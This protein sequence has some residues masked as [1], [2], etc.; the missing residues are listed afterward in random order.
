M[1]EDHH[2]KIM[3][4]KESFGIRFKKFLK[5][6]TWEDYA[7]IAIILLAVIFYGVHTA[8]YKTVPS[9]VFG[10]DVY[11]DRGFVKNIAE[12]NAIWSDAFYLNEIQYYGYIAPAFEA[13]VVKIFNI[14]VDTVFLYSGLIFLIISL[15]CWY[16]LG[17]GFFGDKKLALITAIS[18]LVFNQY[19]LKFAYVAGG[20]FVPLFLYYWIKYEKNNKIIDGVLTG[21]M[22]GLTCLIYGGYLIPLSAIFFG[23]MIISFFK[24]VF[25]DMKFK[26]VGKNLGNQGKIILRYIKKYYI[27]T[28]AFALLMAT[29]FVPL[30][31]KYQ[32]KIVNGVPYWGDISPS[33]LNFGWFIGLIRSM[34]FNYSNVLLFIVSVMC[35]LGIV[36]LLLS[37]SSLQ[38]KIILYSVLIDLV[39]VIHHWITVPL[40]KTYFWPS[41]MLIMPFFL[42]L[43]FVVGIKFVIG[44]I[45]KDEKNN[46][47]QWILYAAIAL[48]LIVSTT[49]FISMKNSQWELYGTQS[50]PYVDQLYALAGHIDN[51][52]QNN[53]VILSNDETGFMLAVLSGRK[54]M[55][56]RRTHA[57]YYV[58]IDKRIADASVAM[59]GR[60]INLTK[61][62]LAE[63]DVKYFY[64]DAYIFQNPMRTR[65]EFKGYLSQNGILYTEVID[66][67]DVA[68]PPDMAVLLPMLVI[69][70]Q[71]LTDEFIS[72]WN[73]DYSVIVQ[74]QV[75][76]QLYR[77]KE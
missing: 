37:K 49:N 18:S 64:M 22:L 1:D 74:G 47:R 11:R 7:L 59:Y 3:H 39:L 8:Q 54:V 62:I 13:G 21:L 17:L 36:G 5:S 66:R 20:I 33:A 12:G 9:P 71:N 69:S 48:L 42:P 30:I 56:T 57:S 2:K 14:R 45:F 58:D 4:V 60:D 70:P 75:V 73:L 72:L 40:F 41:K 10:G 25:K 51:V 29:Y 63:Y 68:V 76:G 26:N 34:F 52:V 44:I 53:Q 16:V 46:N 35:L 27:A 23:Y 19:S 65:P 61:K 31:I 15:I 28:M 55:L 67:Y 32:L 38:K 77:L 24:D 6:L 50:N 43:L